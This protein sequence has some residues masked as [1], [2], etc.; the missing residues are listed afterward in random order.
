MMWNP[1]KKEE[2]EESEESGLPRG[3]L[4]I[5]HFILI[6]FVKD[7]AALCFTIHILLMLDYFYDRLESFKN[8]ICD[9]WKSRW[10]QT[11][12]WSYFKCWQVWI[13]PGICGNTLSWR[14]NQSSVIVNLLAITCNISLPINVQI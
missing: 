3:F 1:A 14:F 8:K 4:C 12:L 2:E 10:S 9:K 11:I 13:L 7:R 6:I 5:R